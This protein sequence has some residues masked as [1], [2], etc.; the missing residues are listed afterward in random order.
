ME[1]C[2]SGTLPYAA[3]HSL[4]TKATVSALVGMS[5]RRSAE[6]TPT[7][8]PVNVSSTMERSPA[9]GSLRKGKPPFYLEQIKIHLFLHTLVLSGNEIK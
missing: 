5:C 8:S 7:F 6:T 2:S 1:T 3:L 4:Q 9:K